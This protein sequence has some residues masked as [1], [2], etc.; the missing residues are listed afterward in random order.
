MSKSHI[1]EIITK[2]GLRL[3]DAMLNIQGE[4]IP[5]STILSKYSVLVRRDDG[6]DLLLENPLHGTQSQHWFSFE[7]IAVLKGISL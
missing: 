5:D 3:G 6:Y 4:L 2:N 1:N 7:S